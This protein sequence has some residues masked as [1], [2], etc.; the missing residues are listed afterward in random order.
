MTDFKPSAGYDTIEQE[1]EARTAKAFREG[2]DFI[3]LDDR[4]KRFQ[5][6]MAEYCREQGWIGDPE[7]VEI[8]EQYSQYRY[9]ITEAGRNRWNAVGI[10]AGH[11]IIKGGDKCNCF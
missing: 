4:R 3:I 10:L 5:Y 11:P 1:F 7:F 2:A 6:E 9:R 8:D